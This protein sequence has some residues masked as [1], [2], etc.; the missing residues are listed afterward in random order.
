MSQSPPAKKPRT[1]IG[2]QSV[3]TELAEAG[4]Q[5]LAALRQGRNWLDANNPEA[6]AG[7]SEQA[8]WEL[9]VLAAISTAARHS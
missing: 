2:N 4:E 9:S 8:T 7:G 6:D 1:I 3:D 5:R